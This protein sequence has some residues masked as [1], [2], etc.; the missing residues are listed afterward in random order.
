MWYHINSYP[1]KGSCAFSTRYCVSSWVEAQLLKIKCQR[2][3]PDDYIEIR[4]DTKHADRDFLQYECPECKNLMSDRE[5]DATW[6]WAGP[7]CN[8]CGCTGM[9]MFASVQKDQPVRSGKGELDRLEKQ[10]KDS[11]KELT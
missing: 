8:E 9:A 4:K 3:E 1:E 7:H 2:N 6:D 11:L 5:L 10:V